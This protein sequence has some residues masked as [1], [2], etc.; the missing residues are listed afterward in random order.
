MLQNKNSGKIDF[1]ETQ[2]YNQTMFSFSGGNMLP[3]LNWGE[4]KFALSRF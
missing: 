4:A 2:D 3:D 1:E